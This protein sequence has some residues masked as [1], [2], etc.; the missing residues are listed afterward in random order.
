MWR[1][2]LICFCTHCT[3]QYQ[4][5]YSSVRRGR[6]KKRERA[7][8]TPPFRDFSHAFPCIM[9]ATLRTRSAA[10]VRIVHARALFNFLPVPPRNSTTDLGTFNTSSIQ[11]SPCFAF[12]SALHCY[13]S[14]A[15]HCVQLHF[16]SSWVECRL[17]RTRR[18]GGAATAVLHAWEMSRNR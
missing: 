5:R 9:C 6:P 14:C 16:R 7:S 8:R 12:K 4:M 10:S 3:H 13:T 11:A 1:V 18:A 17:L 15:R 2:D